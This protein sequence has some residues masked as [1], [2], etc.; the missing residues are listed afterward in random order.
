MA[1]QTDMRQRILG[2][3]ERVLRREGLGGVTTRLIAREVGCAEGTLYVHFRD[4]TQL[5]LAIVEER[6]PPWAEHLRLL[7]SRVGHRTVRANLID[8]TRTAL[9][10]YDNVVPLICS[11]FAEPELLASARKGA[12]QRQTGPV[13]AQLVIGDYLRAEQKGGRVD[14]TADPAAAATALLGGTWFRTFTKHFTGEPVPDD[15]ERFIA[16]LVKNAW[17]GLRPR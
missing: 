16:N 17:A 12:S 5:L 3:A 10:F 7:T 1:R 8:V 14:P 9:G 11:L 13:A 2:A 6:L 4:R 15:D